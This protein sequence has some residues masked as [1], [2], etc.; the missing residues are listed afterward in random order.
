MIIIV[1]Q[2]CS[3]IWYCKMGK[4][5]HT[6]HVVGGGGC[7]SNKPSVIKDTSHWPLINSFVGEI[8]Y[9]DTPA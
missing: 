2:F 6:V 3:G 9:P 4:G 7:G 1:K 5:L 8:V